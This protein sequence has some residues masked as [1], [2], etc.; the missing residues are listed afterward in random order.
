MRN[1]NFGWR[2]LESWGVSGL[3]FSVKFEWVGCVVGG[4]NKGAMLYVFKCGEEIEGKRRKEMK[5]DR[6]G[7][8]IKARKR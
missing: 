8:W 1:P 2:W 7:R 4:Y 5:L 6:Y 3:R